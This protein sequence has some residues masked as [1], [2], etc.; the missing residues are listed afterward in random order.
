VLDLSDLTLVPLTQDHRQ[1][2]EALTADP[3]VLRFTGVPDP[4]P[5]GFAQSWIQRYEEGA[6]DGTRRGFAVINAGGDFVGMAVA[7]RIDTEAREVELGYIVA[8][9]R[10]GEGNGRRVLELLTQW[11]FDELGA[12]R[13]TLIIDV[14]NTASERVARSSGFTREGVMRSAHF[15]QG[16]RIDAGLWSRLPTD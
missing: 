6:H 3:D 5:S 11:A 15:K 9:G 12:L 1:Q 14:T 8:P 4:P 7:P 2:V 13:V 16:R 10:R